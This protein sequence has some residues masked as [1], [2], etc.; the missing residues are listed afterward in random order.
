MDL[1][2]SRS[3]SVCCK[4]LNIAFGSNEIHVGESITYLSPNEHA[5][6]ALLVGNKCIVD[7]NLNDINYQ[8]NLKTNFRGLEI[9]SLADLLGMHTI[10]EVRVGNDTP[11]PF[12]GIVELKFNVLGQQDISNILVP[13]L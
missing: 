9:R 13:F 7:C 10:L 1:C 3:F 6:I 12:S 4:A 11:A 8:G 5:K 2:R